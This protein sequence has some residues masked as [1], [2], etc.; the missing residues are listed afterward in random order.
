MRIFFLIVMMTCFLTA[1]SDDVTYAPVMDVA[2]I[3]RVPKNGIHHVTA[4]E[5]LYTIAWRYG[6]DYRYITRINHMSPPYHLF[7]GQTL[8]LRGSV[9][10][11]HNKVVT[12]RQQAH[13][14]PISSQPAHKI[15]PTHVIVEHEFY[16]PVKLWR[17]PARGPVTGFYSSLNKGINIA[18]H[19]GDP[20][21]ATAAGQIVYSGN[22]LRGYGNLI[23]IKHNSTYLSAYAHNKTILVKE[24]E[25][26]RAGQQI[27]E[28][29]STGAQ[30]VMLHFEIRRSGQPTNPM[31]YLT[32]S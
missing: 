3:E 30:N 21:F 31:T 17:W 15:P 29:G 32:R 27:A 9:A 10:R 18:G 25:W 1:C 14:T 28:M 7:V 11:M 16:T 19:L 4:G 5:S 6:L 8:Y 26:V 12:I 22:R 20:I 13:I 23:I 24:G 2:T